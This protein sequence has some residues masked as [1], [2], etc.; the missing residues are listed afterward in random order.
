MGRFQHQLQALTYMSTLTA[1]YPIPVT[2][3]TTCPTSADI[4]EAL[5]K[6]LSPGSSISNSSLYAPRWDLYSAPAPAYVVQIAS[7]QDVATTV[8]FQHY[9]NQVIFE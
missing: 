5:G 6:Q 2:G 4:E 9:H 1:L 3:A 7:E 8:R